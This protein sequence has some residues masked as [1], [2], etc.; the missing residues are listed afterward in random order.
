ML[1]FAPDVY[2]ILRIMSGSFLTSGK[3]LVAGSAPKRFPRLPVGPAET[4]EIVLGLLLLSVY[5][6]AM[7]HSSPLFVFRLI[8]QTKLG[9]DVLGEEDYSRCLSVHA[10][11]DE[12]PIA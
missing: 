5:S 6:A 10:V 1:R 2:A 3:K 12:N 4:I 8:R 9:L 7:R 11:H